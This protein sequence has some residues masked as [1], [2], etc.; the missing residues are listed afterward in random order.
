M[1]KK[2]ASWRAESR[3]STCIRNLHVIGL[4]MTTVAMYFTAQ[5]QL[6]AV[7]IQNQS[8]GSGAKQ[9]SGI[10]AVSV[11]A[12]RPILVNGVK[13]I[14]GTT[15]VSGATITTNEVGARIIFGVFATLEIS[16]ETTVK[17]DFTDDGSVKATLGRGC[18][19]LRNFTNVSGEVVTPN[20]TA[21]TIDAN[22]RGPLQVCFPQNRLPAS[23]LESDDDNSLFHLAKVATLAIIAGRTRANT[24]SGLDDRGSN[25]GPSTP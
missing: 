9:P 13:A 18:L 15:I 4:V 17:T 20:G 25:P 8:I 1:L 23:R 2:S 22:H 12:N 16:S 19:T 3:C 5:V 7:D 24:A 14:T 11:A 21:G 10:A 6:A